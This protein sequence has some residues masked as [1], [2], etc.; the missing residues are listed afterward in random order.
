MRF[1]LKLILRNQF[2]TGLNFN[3]DDIKKHRDS[4]FKN[5]KVLCNLS[6]DELSFVQR[7]LIMRFL[8]KWEVKKTF[9]DKYKRIY[10]KKYPIIFSESDDVKKYLSN[11]WIVKIWDSFRSEILKNTNTNYTKNILLTCS[12]FLVLF[13]I[14]F[15][16]YKKKVIAYFSH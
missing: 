2:F 8:L 9:P 16:V 6:W 12:G 4:I 7:C 3:N 10:G 11:A 14:S 15:Y 13:L 5:V 1:T